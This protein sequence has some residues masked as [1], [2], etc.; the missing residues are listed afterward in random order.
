MLI[1]LP[2]R[3]HNS[4]SFAAKPLPSRNSSPAV[5]VRAF[6]RL[7]K[8]SPSSEK[9]GVASAR[10]PMNASNSHSH[11]PIEKLSSS[12]PYGIVNCVSS[13]DL[14]GGILRESDE[15]QFTSE[16]LSRI[17]DRFGILGER[18]SSLSSVT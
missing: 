4:R 6:Y 3:F 8:T 1:S 12:L 18:T 10:R 15:L 7:I 17:H 16:R 14:A 9:A 2:H 5:V 13:H 11:C